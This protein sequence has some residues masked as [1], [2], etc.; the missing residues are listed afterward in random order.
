M[1]T[2]IGL[3]LTLSVMLSLG[4]ISIMVPLGVAGSSKVS[5]GQIRY[6]EEPAIALIGTE[7]TAND[8]A[9]GDIFGAPI[10]INRE[11]AVA[12]T[13][14]DDDACPTDPVCN[15]G[16]AYV[17][18]RSGTAWGHKAKL[19][20]SPA[21]STNVSGVIDTDTNW[22]L[23]DSPI[24]VIGNIT[25]NDGVTLTIEPGVVVKFESLKSLVVNGILIAQ[26]TSANPISFTSSSVSPGAG[27]WGFIKFT[28][29]STDASF[30]GGGNYLS[31]SI[32]EQCIVEY[33]GGIGTAFDV[34]SIWADSASPFIG[35]CTV[36]QS[37]ANGVRINPGVA[38]RFE[39]NVLDSN[40]NAGL[41]VTGTMSTSAGA[42]VTISGNIVTNNGSGGQFFNMGGL[43]VGCLGPGGTK[44]ITN[45]I[46]RNNAGGDAGGIQATFENL[47]ISGNEVTGNSA[48]VGGIST[49]GG[50]VS[51]TDNLVQENSGTFG[52]VS[53]RQPAVVL[54]L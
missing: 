2:R 24:V 44:L 19:R 20:G 17:F 30:D 27:D 50:T 3:A 45:N 7:L 42:V 15:A 29:S 38:F 23:S 9:A 6:T 40:R 8:G 51:L 4:G 33:G 5:A 13:W 36:R 11:T 10:A 54:S 31:G 26:G 52:G 32:L 18:A 49:I 25:V 34:G 48:S 43:Y 22:H 46:V 14:G 21:S 39:D 16:S 35:S 53:R 12:G 41:Y 1:K 28:D 47:V 37:A